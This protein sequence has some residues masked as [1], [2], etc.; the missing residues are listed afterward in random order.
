M[1]EDET[2][3]LEDGRVRISH[4]PGLHVAVD[5]PG[6]QV[7]AGRRRVE[8]RYAIEV[9][10]TDAGGR[11]TIT[12]W[13]RRHRLLTALVGVEA[14]YA[15]L[16]ESPGEAGERTFTLMVLRGETRRLVVVEHPAGFAPEELPALLPEPEDFWGPAHVPSGP[17]ERSRG[18]RPMLPPDQSLVTAGGG[19]EEAALGTAA[20]EIAWGAE[21]PLD[22]SIGTGEEAV[23]MEAM[24]RA[25]P[26]PAQGV[27]AEVGANMPSEVHL[28]DTVPVE[29]LLSREEV[30]VFGGTSH[31][32]QVI[33]M[34][35]LR[36]LDVVLLR[37][38]F[39][40]DGREEPRETGRRSLSL[41]PEGEPAVRVVFWLR[42]AHEGEG[43]VQVVVR[44]DDPQPLATLRLTATVLPRAEV[45]MDRASVELG[46]ATRTPM[47]RASF[48]GRVTP[49]LTSQSL[50]VDENLV[51]VVS[52]LS[53]DLVLPGFRRRFTHVVEDKSAVLREVFRTLDDAWRDIR[54][55][56]DPVARSA[57]FHESLRLLGSRLA[58]EVLPPEL[59]SYLRD[60]LDGIDELAVITSGETDIPW[61]LVYVWATD[62]REDP[63]GRGFLGRVG[64]VRWVYNTGHP[65]HLSVRS[66][67]AYYLIPEY[68][69]AALALEQAQLEP[70]YLQAFGATAI[71]PPDA[72]GIARLITSGQVDLLHFAG[73]G[74]SNDNDVPPVR[75]MALGAYRFGAV[76]VTGPDRSGVAFSL[77]D[78]RRSLPDNPPRFEEPGPLVFLNACRIGQAPSTRS[79]VGGFAET[80]LRGGAGAFVGCLWSVGDAPAREFVGAFYQALDKGH[81]IAR[82]TLAGR[83]AAREAGD[84]SWLAYTVYAHPDARLADRP[85]PTP[86]TDPSSKGSVMTTTTAARKA[87]ALTREELRLIHPHV[88]CM[89]DGRLAEG[90]STLPTD[91]DD[92]RT[93]KAD[94]DDLFETR[95]PDF[96][97]MHGTPVPMMLW[98]HGGLVDKAAGLRVAY[99][100]IAWWQANGVFPVHF[101]W[102]T[103]L[104][105][106]LWD[107]VKDSLPGGARG[108]ILDE[109]IEAAVRGARGKNTW[110]A[111]KKTAK[112]ASE[113][114]EGGAWYFAQKLAEFIKANPGSVTVHAAGHSAGSIFHS[115]LVPVMVS[116]GV[117]EIASLNLLAPAIRVDEFKQRIMKKSIFDKIKKLAMFTMTESFEKD[118]TCIGIYKKSLLYLIRGAL[119]D[120][121]GAEILGLQECLERDKALDVLVG[122]AG[123]G[124][125][126]EVMWSRTVGGGPRTTSLSRTHGGFDNDAATMNSLARRVLDNDQLTAG[127]GTMPGARGLA[128]EVSL[129]P[130]EEDARAYIASR[131]E[132]TPQPNGKRALCIGIDMYPSVADQLGGCV[133][134][135]RAWKQELQHAGFTVDI[136]EDADATRQRIVE[137]IQ[138]LIV[139]SKAGDV[140]VLQYS[141]HGTTIDDLD[142]DELEEA[143]RTGETRD[144]A[145]CPVDFR[146]GELLIDDDLGQMWDLLPA[147]VNLTVF[148]DSCHSGGGQRNVLTPDDAGTTRKARLVRM[149]SENVEAYKRKR[150]GLPQATRSLDTE[151]SVYFGACQATEL[152]FESNGQGDFTRIALPRIREFTTGTNQQFFDA[153]LADFGDVR[154]QTPVLLPP[155]LTS[156][157]FLARVSEA[158]KSG[159]AAAPPPGPPAPPEASVLP[160]GATRREQAVASI[161]RGVADLLES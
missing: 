87:P 75:E 76:N 72:G 113:K 2:V 71:D 93:V 9:S 128:E 39:D 151:R 62:A 21:Q 24:T 60:H 107:A 91:V 3:A 137:G 83:R 13:A 148:F 40:L 36:P 158:A 122:K 140:L 70:T 120:E 139:K 23:A 98:A 100:Q 119:E 46:L 10:A 84:I 159:L 130:S 157:T 117:P 38:G 65:T 42:A 11:L 33:V 58:A 147:D 118:D 124:S 138:D 108:D 51:G 25:P 81:T 94:I 79:E 12:T 27:L 30:P 115:H 63:E 104:A 125:K 57:A 19:P 47:R 1:L 20:P 56:W 90:A 96:I 95:L 73:H 109:I 141:G 14:R 123:S 61:E 69:D 114:D 6:T 92:F 154:R 101:V 142:G 111:M 156:R 29:V 149:T 134:D 155:G 44:Q 41:P 54:P 105:E 103:G 161:L 150:G 80:F 143:K 135:A 129:W 116:A 97:T 7:E 16:A 136:L 145:L 15:L 89:E 106:S 49:F 55:M 152:A 68:V 86:E 133:A 22:A 52:E 17:I 146:E 160:A 53:F 82:A 99:T 121:S 67:R 64:L 126:G 102:R 110:D 112:L 48:G 18:A 132:A 74:L 26:E 5:Q 8:V 34:D 66:G 85:E 31:D 4:T 32:E 59:L 45:P 131:Q 127:F 78:L 144:E 50:V 77:E 35:P 88:V 43:E 37:R 28:D 153:V